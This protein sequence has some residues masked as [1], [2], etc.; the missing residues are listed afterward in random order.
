ME[1]EETQNAVKKEF[2]KKIKKQEKPLNVKKIVY[3][4]EDYDID[5]WI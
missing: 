3:K 5:H 1:D 4:G 2:T